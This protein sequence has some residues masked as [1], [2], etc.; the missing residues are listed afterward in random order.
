M[1]RQE[2][3]KKVLLAVRE[4]CIDQRLLTSAL[5]L[6]KRMDAGLEILAIVKGETLPQPLQVLL[7]ALREEGLYFNL[8]RKP[9]LRRRDIVDY[10]NTHECISAVVIDSLEGWE[11]LAQDRSSDPWKKLE[12][13]LVTA[14]PRK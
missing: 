3:E 5:N 9:D 12:C 10:A 6:C 13:P 11:T 8:T 7:E 4:N 1:T 14:T 2:P